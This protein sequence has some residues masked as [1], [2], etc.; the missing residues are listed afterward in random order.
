MNPATIERL[1]R[2][3]HEPVLRSLSRSLP[4][5]EDALQAAWL[6]LAAK[7]DSYLQPDTIRGWLAVVARR[8]QLEQLERATA[9]DTGELP[10]DLGHEPDHA[11]MIDTGDEWARLR[12]ALEQLKPSQRYAITALAL[13]LSYHEIGAGAGH[14]TTPGRTVNTWANRH[15]TEG[16]RA[17]REALER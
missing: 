2:E 14:P 16:R 5:P 3:H 11:A 15:V 6:T 13:G 9:T 10:Y 7:P 17:L 8:H 12:E 1:Y 4:D